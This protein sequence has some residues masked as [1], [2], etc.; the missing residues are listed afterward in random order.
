MH[1]EFEMKKQTFVALV[2]SIP[3]TLIAF[4]FIAFGIYY[5]DNY[6]LIGGLILI[7][8]A[9]IAGVGLYAY[10]NKKPEELKRK[11]KTRL[12]SF[13]S[14]FI[15]I[16]T[17]IAF[18][19]VSPMVIKNEEL[20]QKIDITLPELTEESYNLT[21]QKCSPSITFK[22][23]NECQASPE[24]LSVQKFNPESKSIQ[25]TTTTVSDIL[26][27]HKESFFIIWVE[28]SNVTDFYSWTYEV[29]WDPSMLELQEIIE[30]SLLPTWN[31]NSSVIV[32]TILWFDAAHYVPGNLKG[33]VGARLGDIIGS[34]TS[35]TIVGL[36]FKAIQEGYTTI[37]FL[38]GRWST[39]S[40]KVSD[41]PSAE[42]GLIVYTMIKEVKV[43]GINF[44]AN[45]AFAFDSFGWTFL[46]GAQLTSDISQ[47][48][49]KSVVLSPPLSAVRQS[50]YPCRY[51]DEVVVE[52]LVYSP[53]DSQQLIITL[54][55]D[56]GATARTY[57]LPSG[58][59]IIHFDP[60]SWHSKVTDIYILIS[61]LNTQ[62]VYLDYVDVYQC[63][64]FERDDY[65]EVWLK[66]FWPFKDTPL[67]ISIE[68]TDSSGELIG[69]SAL[70]AS[71]YVVG[72]SKCMFG[73][74]LVKWASIGTAQVEVGL[75]TDW[76][77][78]PGAQRYESYIVQ[79]EIAR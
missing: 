52:C 24:V 43:R 64:N 56:G 40:L 41:M 77:W 37:S 74:Q 47:I 28:V 42:I 44:V 31:F 46:N 18:A 22:F 25:I 10:Y 51:A 73:M 8:L 11:L 60:L 54:V 68:I 2:N 62:P 79:F 58:W 65:I 59:S 17:P 7:V 19:T 57:I 72:T 3:I 70:L 6:C 49:G 35:G 14:V 9:I 71:G 75:W 34:D 29:R 20:P 78:K 16:T 48:G 33:L 63:R 61:S 76:K 4:V 23:S 66:I 55:Y 45:P 50:F 12:I 26:L 13:A 30:G 5:N 15:L 39:S 67:S 53:A 21:Q 27:V 32:P 38:N 1:E 36:K 69:M